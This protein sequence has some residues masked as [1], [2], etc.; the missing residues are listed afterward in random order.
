[1]QLPHIFFAKAQLKEKNAYA[2]ELSNV[3]NQL[4]SISNQLYLYPQKSGNVKYKAKD[5]SQLLLFYQLGNQLKSGTWNSN[6]PKLQEQCEKFRAECLTAVNTQGQKQQEFQKLIH[7]FDAICRNLEAIK[8]RPDYQLYAGLFAVGSWSVIVALVASIELAVTASKFGADSRSLEIT[9]N[10]VTGLPSGNSLGD[11]LLNGVVLASLIT[12]LTIGLYLWYRP[13][14][15]KLNL[16]NPITYTYEVS[17]S[18]SEEVIIHPDK[19]P[20]S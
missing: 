11:A 14:K 19:T 1:M 13:G 18:E 4:Q 12:V 17:Q 6:L 9:R 3:L 10:F 8:K 7:D 15:N 16:E 20:L 2:K 5:N